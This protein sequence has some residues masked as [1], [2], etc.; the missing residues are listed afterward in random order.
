MLI[1]AVPIPASLIAG[2]DQQEITRETAQD[3]SVRP[4]RTMNVLFGE[5][6]LMDTTPLAD[7]RPDKV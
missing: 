1:A 7:L 2:C 4:V 3:E 6:A 5:N